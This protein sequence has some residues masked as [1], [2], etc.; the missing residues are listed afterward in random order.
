MR[1][2]AAAS[3]DRDA[4]SGARHL[5]LAIPMACAGGQ[6]PV[7]CWTVWSRRHPLRTEPLLG[8]AGR[9]RL[10]QGDRQPE[11]TAPIGSASPLA[12]L[13]RRRVKYP[14]SSSCQHATRR[15]RDTL[16]D[17]LQPKAQ[18][19]ITP[20]ISRPSAARTE[21]AA[22][23]RSASMATC[24]R[25]LSLTGTLERDRRVTGALGTARLDPAR[26]RRSTRPMT[27]SWRGRSKP[28]VRRAAAAKRANRQH[29]A[30]DDPPPAADAAAP[31][32]TGDPLVQFRDTVK[33]G[34][35]WPAL[36]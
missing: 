35:C 12:L 10:R 9:H 29:A 33:C 17:L 32:S 1:R 20:R 36:A 22:A 30:R 6:D 23:P 5:Q 14:T 34:L 15:T 26:M 7:R 8:K 21:Y 27:R 28:S 18:G 13:R 16:H 3:A 31:I 25:G 11:R 4:E 19:P 2:S 24:H